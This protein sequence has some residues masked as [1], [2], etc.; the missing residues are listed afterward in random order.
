MV[1]KVLV[2]DSFSDA[3]T[4]SK[5]SVRKYSSEPVCRIELRL[6]HTWMVLQSCFAVCG[7]NFTGRRCFLNSQGLIWIDDRGVIFIK[8][9]LVGGRHGDFLLIFG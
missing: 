8:Q 9:L 3:G 4:L 1:W 7:F 6:V 2:A 5:W